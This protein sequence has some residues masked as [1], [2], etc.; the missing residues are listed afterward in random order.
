MFRN[1]IHRPI[2]RGESRMFFYE[3]IARRDGVVLTE[4]FLRS[5][6]GDVGLADTERTCERIIIQKLTR[7]GVETIADLPGSA[8][9]IPCV[10]LQCLDGSGTAQVGRDGMRLEDIE[11]IEV[12]LRRGGISAPPSPTLFELTFHL[13][14]DDL[15]WPPLHARDGC[16]T[17]THEQLGNGLDFLIR[18]RYV[19]KDGHTRIVS[20]NALSPRSHR[21][22]SIRARDVRDNPFSE[23]LQ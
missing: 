10:M 11:E 13:P 18:I 19:D 20:S 17:L 7:A 8:E 1:T 23:E 21:A 15:Q 2:T 6:F 16:F 12:R 5:E 22:C 14:P 3:C 4:T 9:P